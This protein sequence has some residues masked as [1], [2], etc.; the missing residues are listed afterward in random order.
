MCYTLSVDPGTAFICAPPV[1]RVRCAVLQIPAKSSVPLRLP[2]HKNCSPLNPSQSTLPQL[3]IPL[4]FNSFRSNTYNNPGEV[5]PPLTSNDFQLVTTCIPPSWSHGN[6]RNSSAFLE[7]LTTL[8]TPRWVGYALPTS[9]PLIHQPPFISRSLLF[10]VA[11]CVLC[12]LCVEIPI[13]TR[14]DLCR[15]AQAGRKASSLS[16]FTTHH[17]LLTPSSSF[18]GKIYPPSSRSHH[19]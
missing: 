15:Y 16:L 4:H 12:A 3:L 14:L 5:A 10:S 19:V 1:M 9:S 7:L 17:P 18:Q 8:I 2:F 11:L 13:P 6:A